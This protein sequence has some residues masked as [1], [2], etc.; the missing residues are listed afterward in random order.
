VLLVGLEICS[1]HLSNN[2]SD[3]NLLANYL[4]SD[5][6][7]ACVLGAEGPIPGFETLDFQYTSFAESK[8]LM[9]WD[10]GNLGFEMK[11]DRKLPSLLK[12]NLNA[13][14]ENTFQQ[15]QKDIGEIDEFA[16]HPGGKNI[17]TAFEEALYLPS[18]KLYSS[19]ETLAQ[20]GNMSS[21]T[22]LFVLEALLNNLDNSKIEPKNVYAAA[23]GPGIS[24]ESALIR[25]C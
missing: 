4:F 7:A 9:A 18:D 21:V 15:F 22:V 16:I 3:D 5:G 8:G 20:Y 11:L 24:L 1:L 12:K 14:L 6:C 17:L 25:L 23:F 10:I 13:V 2:K 19:R